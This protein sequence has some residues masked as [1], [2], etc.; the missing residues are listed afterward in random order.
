MHISSELNVPCPSYFSTYC[1]A[2]S[3]FSSIFAHY[4]PFTLVHACVFHHI[5][6]LSLLLRHVYLWK[7]SILQPGVHAQ[8]EAEY[9]TFMHNCIC[10]ITH[11]SVSYIIHVQGDGGF[12]AC[13]PLLANKYIPGSDQIGSTCLVVNVS[14]PT[15]TTFTRQRTVSTPGPLLVAE[16]LAEI[17]GP[18]ARTNIRM[19][20]YLQQNMPCGSFC[21]LG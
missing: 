13:M 9:N 10:A 2:S 16:M 15:I 12:P 18:P 14:H 1:H 6:H 11:K 17:S 8:A 20:V 19:I 5:T 21:L 4:E 7:L 3:A